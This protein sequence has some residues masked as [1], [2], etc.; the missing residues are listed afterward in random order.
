[1]KPVISL[2][3]AAGGLVLLAGCKPE[4]ENAKAAPPVRPVLSIVVAPA[5]EQQQG[6]AGTVQPQYQTDRGFRVLGRIVA[7]NVDV[8]DVVKAGQVLAQIDPLVLDLAVRASE[9]DLVKARAQLSN[10]S[11]AEVRTGT[12]FGRQIANQADFDSVQQARE[13]AAASVQQSEAN[14]AKAREQRSYATLTADMD[15]VVTSVDAEVGQTVSPGKKVLTLARTDIREAVVDLPDSVTRSLAIGAAFDIQLQ[16][17]PTIRTAGKVREIAPQADAATRS[18]RVRIT[19]DQV[20]DAFR[21]GATI[22]ARPVMAAD[23]AALEIPVSAL[24]ERDG[25]ARVWL[26]DP[27]AKTVKTV[28]VEIAVR[29][30]DHARIAGGISAGARI[31][32]A[33]V[34]SL[35]EGLAVKIDEGMIR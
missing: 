34:N 15:G 23:A 35:S 11:A 1:M 4:G 29:E 21:I 5:S 3:L 13:A 22:T 14:L 33:G 8:G 24:L 9:A 10:A 27:V 18:R 31:V 26:V 30:G 17:D 16:A 28:P 12:L 2:A 19:L 7:R 20:V 25:A 6:F 32:V